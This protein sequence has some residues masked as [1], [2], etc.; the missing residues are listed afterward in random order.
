MSLVSCVGGEGNLLEETP[1]QCRLLELPHPIL[2]NDDMAKLLAQ[3]RSATSAPA[4]LRMSFP[5]PTRTTPRA[6][7][8]R[9]A[10]GARRAR[11]SEAVDGDRRRRQP[12]HPQRPRRRRASTRRSRACWR[13]RPCTT[14]SSAA[15]KRVRAGLVV[16]TGEPREVADMCAAHRL[17]RRRGESVPRARDDRALDLDVPRAERA[18]HYVNALEEGPAQD[19]EQDGHLRRRSY[20]GAQIFEAVGI[21]QVRHRR[22]LHRHR[23]R[24][25]AASAWPRSRD[26]SLRAARGAR[27]GR[28]ASPTSDDARRRRQS[29]RGASTGERAPVDARRRSP[30]CRRRCGSRTRVATTSTRALINDQGERADDAARAAGTSC[31]S[32]PP[33]PIEEVEP[34]ASIVRRFATGAMCFGSISQ[35]GAREP[36]HR[37]EPHRRQVE[38]RRRRRGRGALPPDDATATR[39]ARAIKQVASG[40]LRRDG[41]LPR[42]RRRHPDQDGPGR[43]ARRRRAAARA[44]RSTRSSRA[45][46]TRRRA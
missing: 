12:A 3:R 18:H 28:D 23:R 42:Q 26:E 27:Y 5:S 44:T 43:Q 38:H 10:P 33:V 13:R 24:A 6:R 37:D 7:R 8:A 16:E 19:D 21:D 45:C 9:A 15:G 32:G 14:T 31:R 40:A 35:R 30:S 39:G 1:K 17:R 46:A 41:A 4:R 25:S 36:R 20:Q 2:T 11:A 22:L 34:A 29:T